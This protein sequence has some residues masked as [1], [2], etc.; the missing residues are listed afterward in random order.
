MTQSTTFKTEWD[1]LFIGGKWVE[2]STSEVIEVHSPATGELVGKVPLAAPADVDAAC[3]AAR[4]AF[5]DG[6]W[7]HD[8]AGGAGRRAGR[9]AS[10][11][12]KSAPTS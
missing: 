1:K 6:P 5:D 11:S 8:V 3:A 12:W 2:P 4:K 7:P 10:S 9:R